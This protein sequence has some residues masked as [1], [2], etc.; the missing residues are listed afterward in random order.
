M[1]R[2][3]D[4]IMLVRNHPEDVIPEALAEQFQNLAVHQET[5]TKQKQPKAARKASKEKPKEEPKRKKANRLLPGW[6]QLYT[7]H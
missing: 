4:E 7:D 2:V 5:G 6:T 3:G 1:A